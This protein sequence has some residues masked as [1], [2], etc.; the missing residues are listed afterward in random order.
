MHITASRTTQLA[1]LPPAKARINRLFTRSQVSAAKYDRLLTEMQR[2]RGA[3]YLRDGG[4]QSHELTSDGRHQLPIDE[5]SW[6]ILL[7]DGSER[8][9][10]CMRYLE[11]RTTSRFEQ[12]WIRKS[13]LSRHPQW[14][15]LFRQAVEIEMDRAGQRRIGFGE[16]GGWAVAEDR[17]A[18]VDPLR[19]VLAA[20]GLFRHLGGCIGLATA[21]VRHGS[22]SI[23]RRV[24]LTPLAVEGYELPSYF[25]P[26]YRC[27]MEAL[28][29]DSDFPNP[30]Y[31]QAIEELSYSMG[32]IPVICRED[33]SPQWARILPAPEL[34]PPEPTLVSPILPAGLQPVVI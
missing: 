10:G 20:C 6:H 17:R 26:Q 19:M 4:I 8:V 24:G 34:A 11:E 29:F 9:K 25:D 28:R 7:L 23:L 32:Q 5:L 33:L 15:Q 18:T 30:R 27:E 14:G 1:I 21:T 2:L 13:A 16:V 3:A 12:L 22:A 31:A